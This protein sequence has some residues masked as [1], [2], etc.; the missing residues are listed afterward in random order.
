R[1]ELGRIELAVDLERTGHAAEITGCASMARKLVQE[2]RNNGG[3]RRPIRLDCEISDLFEERVALPRLLGNEISRL[4]VRERS[5]RGAGKP[6]RQ[7]A[8]SRA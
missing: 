3:R 1:I 5:R 2:S 4:L 6:C 7:G 8:G